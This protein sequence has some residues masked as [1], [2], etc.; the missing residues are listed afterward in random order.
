MNKQDTEKLIKIIFGDVSAKETD[1]EHCD[2][3]YDC[4]KV[5]GT[6]EDGRQNING[7][8]LA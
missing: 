6:N 8:L 2:A 1:C 5:N 7:C 3:Q 4:Q